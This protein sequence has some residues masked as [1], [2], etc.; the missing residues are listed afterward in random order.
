MPRP[1]LLIIM[2]DQHN[3]HVLR[4]AGDP[5]VR[6]PNLDALAS[7]GVRFD[8]AYC[9]APLCVPSRMGFLSGRS[10]T[11]L[12]VWVNGSLLD[13]RTPTFAHQ[14]S[15]AGYETVMCGRMHFPGPDQ[16]PWLCA[17]ARRR[18]EWRNG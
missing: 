3:P 17:S 13:P 1:N 8:N 11:D 15:L 12:R 7:R 6:T 10:P 2:S 14:L 18:R 4:C 16:A 5:H 9:S